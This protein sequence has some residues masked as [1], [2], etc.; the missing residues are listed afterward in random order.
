[1]KSYVL[2][3]KINSVLQDNK[4]DRFVSGKTRGKLDF[5]SLSKIAYSPK[6]FKKREARQNKDYKIIILV[7]ASGSMNGDKAE[8]CAKGLRLISDALEK[9]DLEYALW[10]FNAD[11]LSL[12]DFNEKQPEKLEELYHNHLRNRLLMICS[13]CLGVYG[14]YD[15]EERKQCLVCGQSTKYI[16]ENKSCWY[17]ADG[18]ALHLAQ[19][20]LDTVSGKHII[21]VL[22][23]GEA[24]RLPRTDLKYLGG[25]TYGHFPLRK[26]IASCKKKR[27]VLCSIGILSKAV[28]N[29][30][31]KENTVVINDSKEIGES[32]VYLIKK[33][34]TR[35]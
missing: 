23:D 2:A 35:G 24:D 1:M 25:A 13:K 16:S 12:K 29:F 32:L 8:N 33:Q 5:T 6:V 3:T 19:E 9:T 15:V 34:I 20:K 31:P 17:N 22:S 4:F 11:I 7:D 14:T 27:T 30:Y 28:N 18:L 26:V 21:V 10:S